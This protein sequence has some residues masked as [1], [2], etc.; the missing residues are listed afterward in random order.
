MMPK[1][2]QIE[3]AVICGRPALAEP[4]FGFAQVSSE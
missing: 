4:S 2:G 1:D 3:C